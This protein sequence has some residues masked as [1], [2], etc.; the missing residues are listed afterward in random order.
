MFTSQL[1]HQ[2]IHSFSYLSFTRQPGQLFKDT[3][4]S[5]SFFFC[6][7]KCRAFSTW[8]NTGPQLYS[9]SS[10][11]R[12]WMLPYK[13]KRTFKW[14]QVLHSVRTLRMVDYPGLSRWAWCNHGGPCKR[15]S[16]VF[17]VRAKDDVMAE[18]EIW[19]RLE[20]CILKMKGQKTRNTGGHWN[21][22]IQG[23]RFSLRALERNRSA[24]TLT[25]V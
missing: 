15:D 17:R 22:I 23:K 3:N 19:V 1:V 10:Y 8:L 16:W 13:A 4:L 11:Q 12:L 5:M 7:N 9:F 21:L 14:M 18:A 20:R 6:L 25:L 24:N 2:Y